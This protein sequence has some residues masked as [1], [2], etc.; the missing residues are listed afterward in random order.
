MVTTTANLATHAPTGWQV[1]P[2]T[3]GVYGG[4]NRPP[5]WQLGFM[6]NHGYLMSTGRGGQNYLMHRVVWEAC[7][8]PIPDGLV[9]N[10]KNGVK[11]D[12]RLTNLEVVTRAENNRHAYD[13]GL[14]VGGVFGEKN[15]NYRVTPTMRAE[16]Q[17]RLDRGETCASIAKVYGVD[18]STVSKIKRGVR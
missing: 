9:I 4:R 6:G 16:I 2:A 8:G 12:N 11:T 17:A 1:D 3:G 15:W 10:H 7:V 14:R 5:G 18:S 13:T